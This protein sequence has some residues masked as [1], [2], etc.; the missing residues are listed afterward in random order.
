MPSKTSENGVAMINSI[1]ST[2]INS[3]N[4]LDYADRIPVATQDNLKDIGKAL[5]EYQP[6]LNEFLNQLINRIGLV[7]VHDKLY[8]NKLKGLKK[9]VLE[10]GDSIEEIFVD[11]AK[12]HKYMPVPSDGNECDLYKVHKPEIVSAF[13]KVNREDQYTVTINEDMIK[14]AFTSWGM[15]DNFVAQIFN[16]IYN[17]DE[18]DEFL[19]FKQLIG[20][21]IVNSHL[22][23]VVK[24][25]DRATSEQFSI[26][27]RANGLNLEYMSRK[28]NQ[29]GVATHTDLKD[30]ILVLRS[31]IVPVLD[32]TQLS[33]SFN[34]NLSQP[35]SGR[36]IVID[37]FGQGHDD[38]I[39]AIIDR[40]FSMI[41]DQLFRTTS[42]YNE[43]HLYW[44]F[45]L[46]HTQII[47]SSPFANAI[48]FTTAQITNAINSVT[49]KPNV[50]GIAKGYSDSVKA[51]V[52]YT[53]E[54]D[55]SVTWELTGGN[56]ANTKVVDGTIY[57]GADETAVQLSVKATSVANDQKSGSA[58][59][60]VL[61]SPNE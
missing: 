48:G 13:H 32:V 17:A 24:P 52:D 3:V 41:Y 46:T 33:N 44:N 34:L 40:D 31:D 7:Y 14:R 25:V 53:G 45:F 9:G 12:A 30:Q 8:T 10:F 50:L 43:K 39:G 58:T 22:E 36:I 19:L 11:I 26:A 4:G 16:S 21:A 51:Y 29:A 47:A 1:R 15:F 18:Y 2:M 55:T 5:L 28:Y 27:M 20:N 35:I 37:D 54:I 23:N 60:N 42:V 38:I 49:I 6:A 57:V 56:S 61:P 59:I